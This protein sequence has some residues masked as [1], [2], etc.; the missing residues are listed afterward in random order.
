MTDS[1]YR[2]QAQR[3]YHRDGDIEI[4]GDAVV[5]RDAERYGTTPAGDEGAYVQAW[6]WVSAPQPADGEEATDGV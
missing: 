1:E 4:D 5:S 3:Q 2:E 6:V